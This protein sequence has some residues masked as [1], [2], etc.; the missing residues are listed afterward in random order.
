M[1]SLALY[2]MLTLEISFMLCIT[3]DLTELALFSLQP[4]Y[5]VMGAASAVQ[6]SS[7]YYNQFTAYHPNTNVSTL[8]NAEEGDLVGCLGNR[9]RM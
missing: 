5:P 4:H 8:V 2:L 9:T 7:F 1:A 6:P 3:Y